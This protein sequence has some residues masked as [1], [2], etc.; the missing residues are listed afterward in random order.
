M[1]CLYV[2]CAVYVQTFLQD[3]AIDLRDYTRAGVLWTHAMD[4]ELLLVARSLC[5]GSCMCV[6]AFVC[7]VVCYVRLFFVFVLNVFFLVCLCRF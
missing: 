1:L 5:S 7:V 6:C 4:Q 2:D 3:A